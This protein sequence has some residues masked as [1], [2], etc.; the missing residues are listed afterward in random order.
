MKVLITG[1]AGRLGFAVTEIMVADGLAVTATDAAPRAGLPV[2]LIVADLRQPATARE[3]VRGHD[4]VV[5]LANH[6]GFRRCGEEQGFT[7]NL[8]LNVNIAE[9]CVV[10]KVPTLIWASSV[11]VVGSGPEAQGAT[12]CYHPY[13]PLDAQTPPNP[14]NLYATSKHCSETLMAYYSRVH[15]LVV[16]TLRFPAII[17]PG[18]KLTFNQEA[19]LEHAINEGFA[20]LH[21]HDAGRLCATLV[22][23]RLTHSRTYF[24]ASRLPMS[25]LTV[26]DLLARYYAG[27]PWRDGHAPSSLVCGQQLLTET[28]WTPQL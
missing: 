28:G 19:T 18:A 9:A 15:P 1:A 14:G 27:I 13:L 2:P 25:S 24:P 22:R 7:D 10:E 3:L 8:A 20:Y 5:H 6:P 11:Q 12:R 23:R 17:M 4:A 16:I 21:A 26:P